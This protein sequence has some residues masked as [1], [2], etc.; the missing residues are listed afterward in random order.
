VGALYRTI[1]VAASSVI[2]PMLPAQGIAAPGVSP[3]IPGKI[4]LIGNPFDHPAP[5]YTVEEHFLSGR[6]KAWRV[7]GDGSSATL[8][9]QSEAPFTT[10]LVVGRPSDPAHFNG[11]V[12]V[13]W[14]NVSI[15]T[16]YAIDWTY[17]H[18]ELLRSGYAYVAVSAQKVG[19]D[20][21]AGPMGQ[22]GIKQV[23]P[24]RY[25]ALTHPGDAYAYDIFSQAARA[26][27][28]D[29][30]LLGPLRPKRVLA[31][32]DSQSAGFLVTYVNA[33]DPVAHVFD[34]YLIHSRFRWGIG[35]D[36][37]RHPVATDATNDDGT[38]D[39]I[40]A[41]VRVPVLTF[42]TETDLT[43]PGSA[44]LGARQGDGRMIRTW[45][46][47]GAA[48][49][50]SYLVA[51]N[52]DDGSLAPA[53]LAKAFT[54]ASDLRGMHLPKP[55][56]AAPQH[57]YVLE[58]ALSTLNRWVATGRAP[59]ST[60]PMG[61]ASDR[62]VSLRLDRNGNALGGIRT[63]WVDVPTARFSG[64]G[65]D[66]E[67]LTRLLGSTQPFDRAQLRRLYPGGKAAYLVKFATALDRAIAQ[68]HILRADRAEIM[69]V[70]AALYGD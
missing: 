34:G 55:V 33:V 16:D 58:A 51:G 30:A 57:H 25:A 59:A 27:R 20:G 47:P 48:H 21:G 50:D 5:G 1:I 28:G 40:R 38:G 23:D 64:V 66:K 68:G 53:A 54:P 19:I 2:L 3:A 65:Q 60:A 18:R 8:R 10:R 37:S 7:A 67:G 62:P 52:S 4:G 29:A 15:G 11:T 63:P 42:I 22:A 9:E 6:A 39:R 44:F 46:V 31:I 43:M 69:A 24:V 41:D 49:A 12:L 13:E 36:A 45:E 70:A 61:V 26:A 17:L 32:G 14:L 56:N 35:L